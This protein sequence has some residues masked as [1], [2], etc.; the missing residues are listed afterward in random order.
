LSSRKAP[1]SIV[2]A[3]LVFH[4]LFLDEES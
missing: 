3:A 1:P 4:Y 2:V